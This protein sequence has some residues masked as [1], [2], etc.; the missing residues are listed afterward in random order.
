MLYQLEITTHCNYGCFY[1]AGRDMKQQHMAWNLF[2]RLLAGVPAGDHVVSLQGEGEPTVHPRFWDMVDAVR[3]R[4]LRPFTITNCSH[5]DAARFAEYF[6][7]FA[8]SIDTLDPIEAER[9]G[10]YKIDRMLKNLDDLCAVID[11]NRIHI[12][13]V[14]Y[15]QPLAAVREFAR[16][17]G[18]GHTVQPLQAKDDYAER[19]PDRIA[20][21]PRPYTY[22][23]RYLDQPLRRYYDVEGREY[24]CC[25]IKDHRRHEPIETLRAKM[26]AR[27]MP[28][29]CEGCHEVL[30]PENIPKAH[31]VA[32]SVEAPRLSIVTVCDA[33]SPAL[34]E[35]LAGIA[36][37]C[38]AEA[39]VVESG[40]S[41][42][43]GSD[44]AWPNVRVLRMKDAQA[45][46]LARARNHAA[47]RARGDW[48][49]FVD[50]GI[51]PGERFAADVLGVL[52]ANEFICVTESPGLVLCA[53]TDYLAV[54][55]LDELLDASEQ[56]EW[57][58][59]LRLQLLGRVRRGL[60]P[61]TLVGEGR[62]DGPDPRLHGAQ[63]PLERMIGAVYVQIKRDLIC[64]RGGKTLPQTV[65]AMIHQKVDDT[66]RSAAAQGR[67]RTAVNI[68][69]PD[70]LV[71]QVTP[72]WQLKRVWSYMI[73]LP[74]AAATPRD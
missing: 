72:G 63:D 19:Y 30:A 67:T 41:A 6:P 3:R 64:E 5:V 38:G 45:K 69:L 74:G 43:S 47:R 14:D 4:G 37:Q 9:I 12:M 56:A 20:A 40:V 62:N 29:A 44:A 27:Q 42:G 26:A 66:A 8:V 25:Y 49:C 53:R 50:A 48:L 73:D 68:T 70:H 35:A 7:T 11:P 32:P 17:R 54:D 31:P 71:V 10:R 46:N 36:A 24:P 39:I 22:R 52:A 18:F 57:D 33:L 59:A 16:T 23:C 51:V 2:E 34:G 28:A 55:G 65:R 58:L 60:A 13:T 1:C 21:R 61:G 15:G